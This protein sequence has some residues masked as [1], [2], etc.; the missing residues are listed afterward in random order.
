[1]S[2]HAPPR[3]HWHYLYI[4][5]SAY[6]SRFD[7]LGNT[8]PGLSSLHKANQD[9]N[10]TRHLPIWRTAMI[11]YRIHG[12][13]R[14][15]SAFFDFA[16]RRAHHHLSMWSPRETYSR[17]PSY[18]DRDRR[19]LAPCT[20]VLFTTFE[21]VIGRPCQIEVSVTLREP[22][23]RGKRTLSYLSWQVQHQHDYH[24]CLDLTA[25]SSGHGWP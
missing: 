24:C 23:W 11:Y 2:F 19:I 13:L 15:S 1:M 4:Y 17:V 21:G 20:P 8:R 18:L 14:Q 6:S 7:L 10:H 3:P 12:R 16:G 22:F 5:T 9:K 25:L